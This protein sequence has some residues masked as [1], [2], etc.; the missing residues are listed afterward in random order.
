MQWRL[1]STDKEKEGK[2]RDWSRTSEQE[3]WLSVKAKDLELLNKVC[4]TEYHEKVMDS[5]GKSG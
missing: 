5:L 3:N 1:G 4:L 2:A